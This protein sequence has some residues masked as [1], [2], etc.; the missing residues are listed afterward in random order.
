MNESGILVACIM[1]FS[2]PR[3]PAHPLCLCPACRAALG[4]LP[5]VAV[6][7]RSVPVVHHLLGPMD[8]QPRV[9]RQ[10]Q[11]QAKRKQP[12]GERA[13]KL[14]CLVAAVFLLQLSPS[15][16]APPGQPGSRRLRKCTC[17]A[18]R[19]QRRPGSHPWVT[20]AASCTCLPACLPPLALQPAAQARLLGPRRW[21]I[22]R[23][24]RSRR[25]IVTWR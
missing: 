24:M 13:L 8:A 22:F 12:V 9:R 16:W 2:A 19:L 3:P 5:L 10:V 21:R 15:S 17:T 20:P 7:F 6:L 11:R 1:P 4:Q 23:I 25:Q 18:A 14:A